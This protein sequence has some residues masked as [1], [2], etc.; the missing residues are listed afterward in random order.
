MCDK[1][2]VSLIVLFLAIVLGIILLLSSTFHVGDTLATPSKSCA[3]FQGKSEC[4]AR[5][6]I[7]GSIIMQ[8]KQT[9]FAIVIFIKDGDLAR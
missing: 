8:G 9:D 2:H 3:K 1:N 5:L 6:V 7:P 4:G